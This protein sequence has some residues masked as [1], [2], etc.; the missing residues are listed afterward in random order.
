MSKLF[1]LQQAALQRAALDFNNSTIAVIPYN[2]LLSTGFPDEAID[3]CFENFKF[4]SKH[5][6]KLF[7]DEMAK[8][9]PE[10]E[11]EDFK[12][13]PEKDFASS[14]A[15]PSSS[16]KTVKLETQSYR[17]TGNNPDQD[18]LDRSIKS[19]GYLL[20]QFPPVIVRRNP[21]DSYASCRV[22]TGHSRSKS[23]RGVPN[24]LV[25]IVKFKPNTPE[26]RKDFIIHKLGQFLQNRSL[27][28]SGVGVEDAIQSVIE[29]MS[30]G[31]VD[32]IGDPNTDSITIKSYL[33]SLDPTNGSYGDSKLE[34]I[35]VTALNRYEVHL[36]LKEK[37][38]I[39]WKSND[40]STKTFVENDLKLKDVSNKVKYITV[41]AGG[42][43]K[44][45]KMAI[46][47]WVKDKKAEVRLIVC[48]TQMKAGDLVGGFHSSLSKFA[49]EWES[50]TTNAN[51]AHGGKGKFP[52]VLYG[53]L[54]SISHL[55]DMTILRYNSK[56]RTFFQ[57]ETGF[58]YCIDD[59]GNKYTTSK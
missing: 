18:D 42:F 7:G 31:W 55:T 41:S 40:I 56:M 51:E 26:A 17:N 43:S 21:G 22:A 52:C 32:H 39:P 1:K 46:N 25:A 23:L 13:I 33:R 58:Q 57:K 47:A 28:G 5:N 45:Y 14:Y 37:L 4:W 36:G 48:V 59:D 9:A 11:F 24:R 29:A 15:V 53:A 3:A 44:A 50:F 30:K 34:D 8:F 54:P 20:S 19:R 27:P 10:L 35:T 6:P 16:D 49:K 2:Q 12:I 38:I